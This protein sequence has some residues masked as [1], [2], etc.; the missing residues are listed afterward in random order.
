[1]ASDLPTVRTSLDGAEVTPPGTPRSEAPA[2]PNTPS[3]GTPRSD[4]E[5]ER[6]RGCPLS[7]SFSDSAESSRDS[8]SASTLYYRTRVCRVDTGGLRDAKKTGSDTTATSMETGAR[9]RD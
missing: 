9:H 5:I 7:R 4:D 6:S 2:T 1:M 3:I 8:G